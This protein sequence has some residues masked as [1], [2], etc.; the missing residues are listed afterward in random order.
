[1]YAH[2][3]NWNPAIAV[4]EEQFLLLAIQ[5]PDLRLERMS[6]GELVIMPPTGGDTGERN[7][8]VNG[9]LW[10]WNQQTKLGKVY[11]SSTGFRLPN[12]ATRSPDAAWITVGRW[13]ALLPEQRKKFLPLCPD[14]AVEIRS[15]SDRLDTIQAKMLEYLANGLRLGWLIDSKT[16]IVEVYRHDRPVEV[17]NSPTKLS[18]EDVLPGFMLDLSQILS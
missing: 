5:N 11:D 2:A 13:Q 15:E 18:G 17:L 12:G 6:T 9:Q 7:S 8:D 16:K 10:Y 4:T 1:M 3:L 14:F